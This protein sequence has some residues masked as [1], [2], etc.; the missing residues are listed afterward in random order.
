MDS[1]AGVILVVNDIKASADFYR[2]LGFKETKNVPSTA[3]TVKLGSFWLELLNNNKVVSE[4]YKEDTQNP[5]KGAGIY[6][7]IKVDDVDK[8]FEKISRKGPKP[9][10]LPKDFPWNQREFIVIDP[11]GYKLAFFSPI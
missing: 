11:D 7:Q 9:A 10:S 4:E 3:I 6:L 5:K 2:A 8:Y 1:V